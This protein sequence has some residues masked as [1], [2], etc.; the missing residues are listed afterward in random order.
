MLSLFSIVVN[1]YVSH[2]SNNFV[3]WN[4]FSHAIPVAVRLNWWGPVSRTPTRRQRLKYKKTRSFSNKSPHL[5]K[6]IPVYGFSLRLKMGILCTVREITWGLFHCALMVIFHTKWKLNVCL[7]LPYL[8][9]LTSLIMI[10]LSAVFLL[11]LYFLVAC[12][13]LAPRICRPETMNRISPMINCFVFQQLYIL[14]PI[15]LHNPQK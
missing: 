7:L 13:P 14:W 5:I 4:D 6:K 9:N 12:G 11:F 3:I 2:P 15:S 8:I 1:S 10:T